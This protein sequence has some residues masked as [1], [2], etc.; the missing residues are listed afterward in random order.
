M[1]KGVYKHHPH[2]GFQK[3]HRQLKLTDKGDFKPGRNHP[4][5]KGGKIKNSSGYILIKNRNH[6]FTTKKGYMY[7][8]RLIAEKYLGRYLTREE[9]IHHINGD[10]LDNRPENLYLFPSR[11]QH[12]KFH[13]SKNKPKLQSNLTTSI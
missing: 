1:P 11:F 10:I 2:Q 12:L 13:N 8:S 5:W 4:N 7:Q 9:V 3:G 6:P